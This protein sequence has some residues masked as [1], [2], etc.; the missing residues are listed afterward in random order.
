MYS[1]VAA[2]LLKKKKKNNNGA[3]EKNNENG[4]AKYT[5][6]DKVEIVMAVVRASCYY[7]VYRYTYNRN[8]RL[9]TD[10]HVYTCMYTQT[11]SDF[12]NSYTGV[13]IGID[14]HKLPRSFALKM[15]WRQKNEY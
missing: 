6:G 1:K 8:N 3:G 12:R 7:C 14:I 4:R 11:G 5:Y 13:R 15:N 2:E 10:S 9:N